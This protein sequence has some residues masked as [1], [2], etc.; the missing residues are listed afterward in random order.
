MHRKCT[1][2]IFTNIIIIYATCKKIF[3]QFDLHKNYL[4]KSFL[5]ENLLDKKRIMVYGSSFYCINGNW[6]AFVSAIV[7]GITYLIFIYTCSDP[8]RTHWV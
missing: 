4:H 7:Q 3:V 5:H 6:T 2:I 8:A 1:K